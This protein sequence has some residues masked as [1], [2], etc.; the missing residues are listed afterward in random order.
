MPEAEFEL[1]L[2]LLSRTMRLTP[3]QRSA[4]ADELRDHLESRLA[5]LM[6]AGQSRE[7]AIRT[8]LEDLGDAAALAADFRAI[9][10]QKARRKMMR[11]SLGA[12]TALTAALFIVSAFWPV[13]PNLAPTALVAQS[14]NVLPPAAKAEESEPSI[15]TV[16]P[17]V[18][19]LDQLTIEQ[20][21]EL[22]LSI[23][24]DGSLQNAIDY[25]SA[26]TRIDFVVDR[27]LVESKLMDTEVRLKIVHSKITVRR[28]LELLCEQVRDGRLDFDTVDETYVSIRNSY[29]IQVYDCRDM[30]MVPE[31][32]RGPIKGN[33]QVFGNYI[34]PRCVA[35]HLGGPK[36]VEVI[37]C[38]IEPAAWQGAGGAGTVVELNGI[39]MVQ[40]S[41][42]VRRR[43]QEM[44]TS[45]KALSE[46]DGPKTP[47]KSK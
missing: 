14:K 7:E 28:A 30:P 2:G 37:P 18:E 21:L 1:Y 42:S 10:I 31:A 29:N 11:Y 8:A 41:G 24:F 33:E 46:K 22:K 25:L 32:Q 27:D 17:L 15:P 4:V 23:D 38:A 36:L 20:R 35:T 47:A 3:E 6:A 26:R 43:I 19:N 9:A 12:V 45:F 34:T 13:S 16:L 39:L 44:I 5:E 40:N